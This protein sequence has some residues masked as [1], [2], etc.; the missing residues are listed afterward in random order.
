MDSQNLTADLATRND[1]AHVAP[2]PRTPQT[3]FSADAT[4]LA[5]PICNVQALSAVVPRVTS[6]APVQRGY[7]RGRQENGFRFGPCNWREKEPGPAR[8]PL[9]AEGVSVEPHGYEVL[10]KGGMFAAWY[11]DIV[12]ALKRQRLDPGARQV[13]RCS[14][15]AVIAR[16]LGHCGGSR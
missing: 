12:D 9:F 3:A 14:D 6:G 15:R 1:C 13:V 2:E 4:A 7:V 10:G 11:E 8:P 16:R 5:E